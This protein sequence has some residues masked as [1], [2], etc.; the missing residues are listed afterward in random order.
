MSA[1]VLA[2]RDV[3]IDERHLDGRKRRRTQILL[4]EKSVDRSS[5]RSREEHAFRIDPPIAVDSAAADEYGPGAT[6][7]INSSASTGRSPG[8]N[9]PRILQKIARHP[10]IFLSPGNIADLL[11]KDVAVELRAC[12]A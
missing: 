12:F 3:A 1:R 11:S 6:N 10:V 7:A 2:K 8:V 5:T 9:G 4:P